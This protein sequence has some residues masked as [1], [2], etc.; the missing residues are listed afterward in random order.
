MRRRDCF[1]YL[2]DWIGKRAFVSQLENYINLDNNCNTFL[3]HQICVTSNKQRNRASLDRYRKRLCSALLHSVSSCF[4][5]EVLISL[6]KVLVSVVKLSDSLV[7]FRGPVAQLLDS[8]ARMVMFPSR[9]V[10]SLVRLNQFCQRDRRPS[11]RSV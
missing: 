10:V 5:S 6:V 3:I 11:Q 4:S 7:N 9:S 2:L 1:N 8:L